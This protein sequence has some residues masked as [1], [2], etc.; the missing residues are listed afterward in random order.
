MGGEGLGFLGSRAVGPGLGFR[1]AFSITHRRRPK[2][3]NSA[4]H[5]HT[6][7]YF[8]QA[9]ATAAPECSTPSSS[10]HPGRQTRSPASESDADSADDGKMQ[11]KPI[12]QFQ[13][14][15]PTVTS[16]ADTT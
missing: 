3:T 14:G 12:P 5:I 10:G 11:N 7:T 6:H 8:H 16:P 15:K 2:L 9:A 1:E 4:R 13:D